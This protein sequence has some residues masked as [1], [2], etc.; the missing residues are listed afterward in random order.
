M[1]LLEL[2]IAV[3][4]VG[5][6]VYMRHTDKREISYLERINVRLTEH[7]KILN[8]DLVMEGIRAKSEGLEGKPRYGEDVSY[9]ETSN[10]K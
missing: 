7:I 10:F 8:D 2:S 3:V 1:C 6:C 5:Y 4:F 9:D